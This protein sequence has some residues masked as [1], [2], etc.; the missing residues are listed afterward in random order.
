MVSE[1]IDHHLL[2][3]T[4]LELPA[5]TEGQVRSPGEALL[6]GVLSLKDHWRSSKQQQSG[7]VLTRSMR[8]LSVENKSIK[9]PRTTSAGEAERLVP[10]PVPI[11]Q[12]HD[13]EVRASA[14]DVP[15]R[16]IDRVVRERHGLPDG[17]VARQHHGVPGDAHL[18]NIS[19]SSR[20]NIKGHTSPST[21]TWHSPALRLWIQWNRSG[22]AYAWPPNFASASFG[23]FAALST[24]RRRH[25]RQTSSY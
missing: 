18:Q 11:A 14:E 17:D 21:I 10:I 9:H 15:A 25:Q 2:L 16:H 20:N 1:R 4:P 19:C 3:A 5:R 13:G 8:N 22:K 23:L 6:P 12:V 24:P 7:V